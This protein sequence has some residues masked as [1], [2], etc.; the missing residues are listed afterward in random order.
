MSKKETILKTAARLFAVQGFE[1]TTTIQIAREAGE[2]APVPKEETAILILSII[3]GIVR[4][5]Q[6]DLDPEK[7][8]RVSAVEF[9]RRSL[10]KFSKADIKSNK[11]P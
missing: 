3:N 8:L 5:S 2:F 6:M 9:C 10:M 7:N 4:C 1:A 11:L